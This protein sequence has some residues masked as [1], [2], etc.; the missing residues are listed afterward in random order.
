MKKRGGKEGEREPAGEKGKLTLR[1]KVL[2][3]HDDARVVPSR[4]SLRAL[5]PPP[6]QWRLPLGGAWAKGRAR[7]NGRW[8]ALRVC[9]EDERERS[10]NHHRAP[11]AC[12]H[13][14]THV[15]ART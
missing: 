5:F 7:A 15:Y 10:E 6:P 11:Y 3:D 9:L 1:G 4:P 14:R 8:A 13:A 2:S 12:T